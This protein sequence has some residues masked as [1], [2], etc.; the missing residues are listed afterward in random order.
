MHRIFI[1]PADKKSPKVEKLWGPC[2]YGAHLHERASAERGVA[3]T[4]VRGI[5][6][7]AVNMFGD[8]IQS[9]SACE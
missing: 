6:S 2:L 5:D 3:R 4:V 1:Y 9:F 8:L 7:A